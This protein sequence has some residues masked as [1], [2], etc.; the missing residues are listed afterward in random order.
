[1]AKPHS[2]GRTYIDPTNPKPVGLTGEVPDLD[3]LIAFL[4]TDEA[5]HAMA[6][7]GVIADTVVMLVES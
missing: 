3:A 4:R 5:A 7:D 1:M 2:S 6:T